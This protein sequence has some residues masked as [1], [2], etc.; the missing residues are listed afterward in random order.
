MGGG[1]RAGKE[2]KGEGGEW[3]VPEGRQKEGGIGGRLGGGERREGV[4]R[5]EAKW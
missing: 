5:V 4:R 2:H 3:A 1:K